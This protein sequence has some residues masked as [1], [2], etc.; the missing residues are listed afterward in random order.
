MKSCGMKIDVHSRKQACELEP[1]G[2]AA[3]ISITCPGEPAP[4]KEGWGALLRLEFDDI[5]SIEE[6]MFDKL[7]PMTIGQANEIHEFVATNE[8]KD[9]VIHC[10]A[11]I[12]RSVSVGVFLEDTLG[13]KL[14]I[15]NVKNIVGSNSL[16]SRQLRLKGWTEHFDGSR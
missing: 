16:V 8:G 2:D 15:H 13:G 6:V 1:R 11:G 7:V 3:M 12:N 5:V 10:D 14:M 4:L 9:F